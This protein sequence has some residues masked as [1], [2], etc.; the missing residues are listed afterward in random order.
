MAGAAA[1][2]MR[3]TN[4]VWVTFLTVAAMLE[5]VHP[6]RSQQQQQQQEEQEEELREGENESDTTRRQQQ[7]QGFGALRHRGAKRQ[8]V[9]S[10]SRGHSMLAAG[11]QEQQQE[12]L[13]LPLWHEV[14]VVLGKLWQQRWQLL[15]DYSLLLLL[16]VMFA[17]FVVWNKGITLGD[18][19]AHAPVLHLMQPLYFSLFVLLAA[20]LLLLTPEALQQLVGTAA[21]AP[22]ATAAVVIAAA[23]VC[24]RLVSK[25][26]LEHPY[27]LADNR[28]YTFYL[29]RK[30]IGRAW[31][32]RYACI[33]GYLL[34]WALLVQGL[35][36]VRGRLWVLGF[37]ASTVVTLAPAWLLEFR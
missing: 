14:L 35:S 34:A 23:G 6:H 22:A 29:W 25:Y 12:T 11:S 15:Q 16:P 24:V 18:R 4:A 9:S 30:V 10:S 33:P 17:V 20:P 31:W 13:E 1:I 27:L 7:Q 36:R 26:T 32:V 5:D 2:A 8:T 28:H 19:E 3:Q 37:V 21:A